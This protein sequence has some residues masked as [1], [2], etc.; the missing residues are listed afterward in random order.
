[1]TEVAS[2][3]LRGSMIETV[4]ELFD[5]MLSMTITASQAGDTTALVGHR[6]IGHLSFAGDVQGSIDIQVGEPFARTMTAAMLGMEEA[7]IESD[8]EVK[9]VIRESCNI[10]GG[11]LK[12]NFVDAGFTCMISP[13]ALT[14]GSDFEIETRNMERYEKVVFD[15]DGTPV[16]TEICVKTAETAA[17]DA[18]L[19][20]KSIDINKFNRLDMISTAG[21][22]VLEL[23]D[24]MLSMDLEMSD[25]EVPVSTNYVRFM[26]LV[27]FAGDVTGNVHCQIPLDFARMMTARMLGV[28]LE[29]ISDEGE[30]KD[31]I[32]EITNIIGGNL[33]AGFCDSGLDCEISTPSITAGKD[34][35]IE[36]VNM[37]RYERFSFR[38]L[39]YDLFAQVCV[40]I[41]EEVARKKPPTGESVTDQASVDALLNDERTADSGGRTAAEQAVQP[42][43]ADGDPAPVPETEPA[44]GSEGVQDPAATAPPPPEAPETERSATANLDLLLDIPLEVTVELGRTRMKIKDLMALG[45]GSAVSLNNLEGEPLEILA[46]DQLVA[47]GEVV[48]E[49][50]KYGIRVT[51]I[52]SRIDRIKSIR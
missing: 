9:D 47:R 23:F 15:C 5:T 46:N 31:V 4:V 49:G 14:I 20:L 44:S 41:D 6:M 2:F 16:I 19:K 3:N 50:E 37:D 36:T 42:P 35:E 17:E 18:R 40:K 51:E 39:D 24:T 13:P 27:N 48:V 38:Y 43:A 10:I 8:E 21:D 11:N 26:G 22:K 34:F 29:D 28:K 32:G 52:V 1:M 45:P 33:K 25:A 30:V 7:E 12:T